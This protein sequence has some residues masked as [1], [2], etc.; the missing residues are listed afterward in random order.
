MNNLKPFTKWVGGKRQLLDDLKAQLPTQ[1]NRYLEPFVGGGALFFSLTPED[2]IINDLNKELINVYRV[3]KNEPEALIAELRKHQKYNSK[4]Y[5]LDIRSMDRDDRFAQL[6]DAKKA[7]RIMYMLRVDF[8]GLYRVNLK[9]QFNVPYGSNKNPTI[10]DKDTIYSINQY[11][12]SANIKIQSTDFEEIADQA[13]KD[14][15]IYFDPPYIPLTDTSS[16]TAY[17]KSGFGYK[18]QV[19]LRDTCI[20]L[21]Q[22]D[23]RIMVSNSDTE[24]TRELYSDFQIHVVNAKRSINADAKKRGVINELIITNY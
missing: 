24:L 14:D 4:E 10:V 11:L 9:G 18:E 17:T 19:R 23:V 12:N 5:Y 15:F 13:R 2:A 20:K 7:A 1:Y 6:S 3:I 16:F 8:N 21:G 22:R